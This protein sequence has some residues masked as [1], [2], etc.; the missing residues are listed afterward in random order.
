MKTTSQNWGIFYRRDPP[1]KKNQILRTF[2]FIQLFDLTQP[3]GPMRPT[4][5]S[6]RGPIPGSLNKSRE[7]GGHA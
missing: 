2:N 1:P 7:F 6:K 5:L 4:K 3:R